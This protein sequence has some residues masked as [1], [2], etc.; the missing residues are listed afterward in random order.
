MSEDKQAS[1]L[2]GGGQAGRRTYM[3][4]IWAGTFKKNISWFTTDSTTHEE[5]QYDDCLLGQ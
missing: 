2:K 5:L 4:L 3:D 1:F